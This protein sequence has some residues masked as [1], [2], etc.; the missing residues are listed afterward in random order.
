MINWKNKLKTLKHRCGRFLRKQLQCRF[1]VHWVY[2]SD[3]GCEH[4]CPDCGKYFPEIKW[5]RY[6]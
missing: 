4:T 2:V 5:P 6:E 3:I 1:D